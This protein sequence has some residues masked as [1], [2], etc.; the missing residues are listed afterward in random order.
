MGPPTDVEPSELWRKLSETPRPSDVVDFPRKDGKGDPIGK[1]RIQV[2]TQ[3]Q[4]DEARERG[5]KHLVETKKIPLEQIKTDLM[6]EVLGDAV[7]R[8]VLALACLTENPIP[9]TDPPRYG[10]VFPDGPSIGQKLSADEVGVLFTQYTMVQNRFG[11]YEG[12]VHNEDELNAWIKRLAEGASAYPLA[13]LDLQALLGLCLSLAR[14]SYTLCGLL[15]SSWQSLPPSLASDL[16]RFS[17]GTGYFSDPQDDTLTPSG[18]S[19]ADRLIPDDPLDLEA[20]A[21]IAR[22]LHKS[23]R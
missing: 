13:A 15:E 17:L 6:R 20:A 2:L 3:E 18:E 11:P 22:D 14:R 9:G 16:G 1:I 4:H 7:A 8:E 12:N 19:S 21:R 23:G 10:R 5:Q